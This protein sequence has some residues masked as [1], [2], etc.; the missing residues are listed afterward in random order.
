M[1]KAQGVYPAVSAWLRWALLFSR[2]ELF[3]FNFG[4]QSGLTLRHFASESPAKKS[5]HLWVKTRIRTAH[6]FHI[7]NK[8]IPQV[9][10]L[11]GILTQNVESCL[12]ITAAESYGLL[13]GEALDKATT[14]FLRHHPGIQ[15]SDDPGIGFRPDEAPNPLPEF[16][17]SIGQ[18]QFRKRAAALTADVF[19]LRFCQWMRRIDEWQP[20]DDHLRQCRA[21]NIKPCPE[22]VGAK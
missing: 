14:I 7:V 4:E 5:F 6:S 9:T 2:Y 1:Y 22:T 21:W 16:N 17:H 11:S 19:T 18:H 15:D 10:A 12:P 8:N 20:S 13:M 3:C